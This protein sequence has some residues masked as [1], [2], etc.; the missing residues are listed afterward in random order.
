MKMEY[1]LAIDIGASSGRH[2]L[3]H[4]ENDKI[5]LEEI[6]R[7]DNYI[8]VSDGVKTWNVKRLYNEVING[9]KKAK[10][11]GKIPLLRESK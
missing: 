5:I 2:M 11:I 4:I 9:L 10:D 1:V 6:Y 8:D 7:F 3:A